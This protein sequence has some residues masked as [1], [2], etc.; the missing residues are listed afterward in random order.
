MVDMQKCQLVGLFPQNKE[1]AI[2]ELETFG[3]IEPPN[4]I[5]N[6]EQ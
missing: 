1:K 4:G 6:L 5:H 2:G 3:E